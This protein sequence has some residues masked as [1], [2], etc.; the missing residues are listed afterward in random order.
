[1][2]AIISSFWWVFILFMILMFAKIPIGISLLFPTILYFLFNNLGIEIVAHKIS[3]S[4]FSFTFVPVP[5]FVWTG[6]LMNEVGA[7]E[8]LFNMV[9]LLIGKRRGG[10]AYVNVVASL[11]FSGISGSVLA[12]VGGLGK[13]E[14]EQMRIEKYDEKFSTGITGASAI[15]GPIFPPSVPLI[16]LAA[17]TDLP[18]Y[19]LLLGGI[20]PAIVYCGILIVFIMII[21]RM[22]T[23]GLPVA[24]VYSISKSKKEYFK[25]IIDGFPT[26][27]VPGFLLIAFMTGF[28]S[29]T[30]IGMGAVA[31]CLL[32]GIIYRS[33]TWKKL[34]A[35][36]IQV[37]KDT[38]SVTFI[39]VAA[40]AFGY[41]M[42][43][44]GFSGQIYN[45]MMGNGN[46][47]PYMYL[48]VIV[49]FLLILGM[50]MDANATILLFGPLFIPIVRDMGINTIHFGVLFIFVIMV[51]LLTPPFGLALFMLKRMSSLNFTEL[52]KGV[53]PF[54][55]PI[56]VTI[57]L[58]MFIPEITTMIPILI[59]S[60]R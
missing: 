36:M 48:I 51:G 54:F 35:S 18:L 50:F 25:T 24:V 15:V 46:V 23:G 3:Y 22:T 8:R 11:V 28:L 13:I 30:E 47:S 39:V 19:D 4:L 31:L 56:T 14:L 49:I 45:F 27:C 44:S 20:G 43:L 26:L 57:V 32:L 1:M 10:S 58:L 21:S 33:L 9:N 59:K 41:A 5:L 7:S 34:F 12:D 53:L 29:P 60:L 52:F 2:V 16:L 6:I 40:S 37:V 17:A 42:T 55:I 38:A